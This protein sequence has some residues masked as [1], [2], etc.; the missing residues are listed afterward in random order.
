MDEKK[1]IEISN[2]KNL[3]SIKISTLMDTPENEDPGVII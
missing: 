3:Q 2:I 1:L